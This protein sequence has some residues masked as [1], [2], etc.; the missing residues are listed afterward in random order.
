PNILVVCAISHPLPLNVHLETLADDL[1]CCHFDYE[2]YHPQSDSQVKE[3]GIRS[4]IVFGKCNTPQDIQCSTSVCL[5]LRLALKLFR[6]EP[7]ISG[8]EWN[9]TA[10]HKSSPSFPK[11]V[12]SVRH[13]IIL[14]LQPAHG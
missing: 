14:S 12:G 3:N 9:V 1:G 10:I 11:L 2:S 6:G 13:E 4:L 8:L 5:R 7:A